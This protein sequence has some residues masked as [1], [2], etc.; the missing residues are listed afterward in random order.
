[1]HR[2]ITEI[3]PTW[4]ISE[5][6]AGITTTRRHKGQFT[7][8]GEMLP[9]FITRM[10]EEQTGELKDSPQLNTL[11][12]EEMMG[13]TVGRTTYPFLSENGGSKA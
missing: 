5:N 3:N 13:F 9:D 10:Q 11:F 12:V 6:V 4:V 1:M 7:R 2:A 8:W